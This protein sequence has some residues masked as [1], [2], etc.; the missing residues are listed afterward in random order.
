[1]QNNFQRL[2]IF[3]ILEILRMLRMTYNVNLVCL[4]FHERCRKNN[5]ENLILIDS[6]WEMDLIVK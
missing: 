4:S 3:R 1:M 6:G 5:D 2:N